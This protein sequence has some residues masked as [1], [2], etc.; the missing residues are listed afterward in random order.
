M[1]HLLRIGQVSK[2]Y[3]ISL[4]TLRH[5][6]HKGLLKPIVDKNNS[7]RYYSLKHL[8]ILEMILVGKYMEI[9]LEQMQ[10][11]LNSES[12][13]DY[14]SMVQEQK[15]R[16]LEKKQLLGEL[17]EF[18]DNMIKLLSAIS[19]FENAYT[20][21]NVVFEEINKNIY[22]MEL[23]EMLKD[24]SASQSAEE[25]DEIEQWA[26]YQEN[27][28][29][30][31][32]ENEQ[33]AGF[34]FSSALIEP[35]SLEKQFKL[36]VKKCIA[37]QHR[38]SGCYGKVSFWGNHAALLKYLSSL[39]KHFHLQGSTLLANYKFALLHKNLEHEYFVEIYFSP[40]PRNHRE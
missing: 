13:D 12:I 1:H 24:K 3:G 16:I 8:D 37:T 15:K 35:T 14:L 25:V 18:S 23:S 32:I 2:L 33:E 6:D 29:G 7:Y 20:F 4:D 21:D 26:F 34:S 28:D 5:Y 39:Y 40:N 10:K 27:A 31:I 9:P 19:E 22:R 36:A 38:I 30:T 17:E 11:R